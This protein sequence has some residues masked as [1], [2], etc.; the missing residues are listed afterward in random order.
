MKQA[1]K[2]FTG[3]EVIKGGALR[4]EPIEEVGSKDIDFTSFKAFINEG[5]HVSPTVGRDAHFGNPVGVPAE[6][7]IWVTALDKAGTMDGLRSR[8]TFATTNMERLNGRVVAND[9]YQMGSIFDQA[10][11]NEL[12]LTTKLGG[13]IEPDAE[14]SLK[15]SGRSKDWRPHHGRRHAGSKIDWSRAQSSRQR[16]YLRCSTPY[17]RQTRRRLFRRSRTQRPDYITRRSHVYGAIL[18]RAPV[19]RRQA[20][21][22]DEIPGWASANNLPDR[23]LTIF[24][25]STYA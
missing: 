12:S 8:R 24:R 18:G 16:I 4:R 2:H 14:Y 5:F 6:T 21:T 7:G 22:L 13:K 17:A 23:Q 3:I 20:F 19:R 15:L 9:R 11:T 1:G 25:Q 10:V